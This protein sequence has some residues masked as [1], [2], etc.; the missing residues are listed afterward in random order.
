MKI[1]I[2]QPNFFP[3][4]SYYDLAKRVDKFIF[5]DDALYNNKSWVNKTTLKLHNRNYYFR[6]PLED[7]DPDLRR[8][9]KDVTPKSNNWK[10][11][12]LKIIKVQY[13]NSSNFDFLFP[14]IK[15]II[16]IPSNCLAHTSAYSVFRLSQS[17]FESKSKFTF[18]SI[19]YENV[20][21]SYYDKILHICKKERASTLYTFPTKTNQLDVQKFARYDIGVSFFT[22]YANNLSIIDYLMTNDSYKEILKKECNLLQDERK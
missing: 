18:S 16:N 3:L 15:E 13:K 17:I 21:L 12:F 4:R 8:T 7:C 5:L 10:K 6:I 22:S 2:I 9:T 20:K 11:K 14:I 1:A 19:K